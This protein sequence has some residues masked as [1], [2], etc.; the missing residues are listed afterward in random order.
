MNLR[1]AAM[2][3]SITQGYLCNPCDGWVS[4]I[5]RELN[6]KMYNLGVPGDLSRNMK[7]RFVHEV[8]PR[9]P[10]HCIILGGTNDAFCDVS[11]DDYSENIEIMVDNCRNNGIAPIIGLPTPCLAYPEE[12][13]LEEY[14]GWLKE[15]ADL[16]GLYVIDFYSALLDIG[17]MAV[18]EEYFIDEVHPNAGGYR[19]MADAA[20]ALFGRIL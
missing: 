1:I 10:S 16:E 8:L 5:E 15:Y 20:K 4:I 19:M 18:R 3:D 17:N 13:I 7:R 11:L 14:R 9:G 2:G 12:L 6:I